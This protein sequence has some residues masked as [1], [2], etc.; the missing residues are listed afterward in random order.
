M[1]ALELEGA[2]AAAKERLL[3][4]DVQTD[5]LR[6][7]DA[8]ISGGLQY[9]QGKKE[10]SYVENWRNTNDSLWWPAR[11]R[12]AGTF[13]VAIGYAADKKSEGGAFVV[14]VGQNVL[15][16][17]VAETPSAPV[18]LGKV[19]LQPGTLHIAVEGNKIVG[20][21]LFRLRGL[22]LTPV[23]SALSSA[24]P[25]PAAPAKVAGKRRKR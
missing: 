16:G 22:T 1:I 10:N 7:F 15:N 24:E 12:E 21:E 4:A 17:T 9:A 18:V 3:S 20:P 8:K 19:T 14:R 11:V 23:G 5:V 25:E 13:E 6:A 2:P